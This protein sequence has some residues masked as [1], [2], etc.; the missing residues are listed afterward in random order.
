MLLSRAASGGKLASF[1]TLFDLPLRRAFD[2]RDPHNPSRR[3]VLYNCTDSRQNPSQKIANAAGLPFE[4]HFLKHILL[5]S[6]SRREIR[7]Q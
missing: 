7:R 6:L 4:A 2:Q 3:A 1:A 5:A